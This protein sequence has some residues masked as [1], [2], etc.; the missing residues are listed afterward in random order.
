MLLEK[1]GEAAWLRAGQ[2]PL[3]APAI[4]NLTVA[5]TL[6]KHTPHVRNPQLPTAAAISK[7]FDSSPFCEALL[8]NKRE[9]YVP[10]LS[11]FLDITRTRTRKGSREIN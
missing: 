10:A 7:A 1:L 4:S 11:P 2:P 8:R 9:A 5:L 3:V 6:H